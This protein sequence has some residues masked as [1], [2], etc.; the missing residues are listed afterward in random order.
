[1]RLV[2]HIS[3]PMT[4][5][6]RALCVERDERF[7]FN[8]LTSWAYQGSVMFILCTETPK[9]LIIHGLRKRWREPLHLSGAWSSLFSF[10]VGCFF[11]SLSL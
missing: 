4:Q 8:F 9:L 2:G 5:E 3:N 7:A 1:M 10:R 11:P 6:A